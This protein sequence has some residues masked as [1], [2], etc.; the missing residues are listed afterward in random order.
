MTLGNTHVKLVSHFGAN[1]HFA[2]LR[3][4]ASAALMKAPDL[5]VEGC[6]LRDE[7]G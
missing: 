3:H 4:D 7:F 5:D 2:E 6:P 1:Y